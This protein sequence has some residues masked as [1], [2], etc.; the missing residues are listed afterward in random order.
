MAT[1]AYTRHIQF[2]GFDWIVKVSNNKVGPGPNLFSDSTS[3]VWV[4]G[5]GKLH[6]KILKQG[7]R[8]YCSEVI[9]NAT[10]GYGTYRWY[11]ESR[12]DNF[13]PSVVLGLFTWSDPAPENHREIDIEMSKWADPNN[14][15]AQYVIQPYDVAAN[16]FRFNQPP[17]TTSNHGFNWRQGSVA[18]TSLSGLD[19][20]PNGSNVIQQRTFT[21]GIPTSLDE[22]ARINLWLFRGRAPKA[23]V[24]VVIGR[25]EF[26]P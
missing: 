8:W 19:P 12:V 17:V 7:G 14:L 11:L 20:T 26:V 10:L 3:S 25:F 24:E 4:D 2:S 9:L 13:D 23:E 1:Q 22:N 16:I 21:N 5:S 6:M 15:N 18:F